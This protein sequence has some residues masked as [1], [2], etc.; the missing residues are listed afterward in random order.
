[1]GREVNTQSL[2][3]WC[4][5]R[6][7]Y[8]SI[9]KRARFRASVSNSYITNAQAGGGLAPQMGIKDWSTRRL[10]RVCTTGFLEYVV[11]KWG[12]RQGTMPYLPLD[13]TVP[14]HKTDK[15]PAVQA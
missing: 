14:N 9:V 7:H 11:A 10:G 3:W 2:R 15:L 13:R 1:M 4:D 8:F 6:D 12:P 5:I